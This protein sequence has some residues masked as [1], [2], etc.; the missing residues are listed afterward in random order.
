MRRFTVSKKNDG[1]RADKILSEYLGE[2]YSRS[3]VKKLVL[4]DLVRANGH[5]V[6]AHKKLYE[7]DEVEFELVEEERLKA[8]RAEDIPL[9]IVFEDD[10]LIAINKKAGMVVH[11]AAGNWTG[12]LVNALKSHCGR[13]AESEE[14][15]R[16]GLVH[17]LDKDTSGIILA[18]KDGISL[19]RLRKQFQKRTVEK[20]YLAL[21]QGHLEQDK[22]RI[23]APIARHVFKRKKMT[24]SFTTGKKAVSEYSVIKR[25]DDFSLVRVKLLTGRTH[26]IRVHFAYIS[27][28]LIG[29]SKYGGP[30][31]FFRQ[32][33]HA[34]RIVFDHPSTGD[35]MD[36]FCPV[37]EDMEE[38]I[39]TN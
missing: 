17:R 13:L 27:H 20:Y 14:V 8:P 32:A 11:P 25:Y 5:L 7:G 19:R 21:A 23:D 3:Y 35:R 10:H 37:P 22:G 9:D 26:Q 28:P 29:D 2:D 4:K 24:V 39:K 34:E 18:A 16:P 15:Y 36:L 1:R 33:L 12:T 30:D 6:K 31:T 38:F